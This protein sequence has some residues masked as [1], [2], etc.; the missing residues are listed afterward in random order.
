MTV[1]VG[2]GHDGW[3]EEAPFDSILV[4]AAPR[5]IP[6][7]LLEQV[8]VGGRLVI[9]IGALDQELVR[10]TRR[11]D[12]FDRETLLSVRFVPLIREPPPRE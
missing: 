10:L 5:E 6:Q 11:E 4:T 12:G 3:P 7:A 2:D 8:A 1:R 9:P